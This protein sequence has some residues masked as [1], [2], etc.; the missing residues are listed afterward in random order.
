VSNDVSRLGARKIHWRER[1]LTRLHGDQR[2]S[3]LSSYS[4]GEESTGQL[5]A[6]PAVAVPFRLK[7]AAGRRSDGR[8]PA[9]TGRTR[10]LTACIAAP[11][12]TC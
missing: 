8:H 1:M 10:P 9:K 6:S 2:L 12:F 7:S 3:E 4:K 5:T 11:A